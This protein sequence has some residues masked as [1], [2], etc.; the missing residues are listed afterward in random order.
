VTPEGAL[1]AAVPTGSRAL[2]I[3]RARLKG[4]RGQ[5]SA[6]LVAVWVATLGA[7]VLGAAVD[8]P[9]LAV[10]P[11]VVAVV[12]VAIAK[13]PLRYTLLALAFLALVLEN[14]AENPGAGKWKSPVYIVG[15]LLL[16]NLN[17]TLPVKALRFSGLDLVTAL[18]FAVWLRRRILGRHEVSPGHAGDRAPA[19]QG[20]PDLLR[21]GG[22]PDGLGHRHPRRLHQR[23]LADAEAALRPHHLRL[24]E[25]DVPRAGR[26]HADRRAG[27]RRGDLE[28]AGRHVRAVDPGA[29]PAVRHQ[30]RGLRAVRHRV[31]H[32]A[33]PPADRRGQEELPALPAGVATGAGWSGWR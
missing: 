7:M 19:A 28:G 12:L 9:I 8:Q 6:M 11:L 23:A 4:F 30:P 14:P 10:V 21:D 24:D 27:H 3:A 2:A 20:V 31:L 25:R 22:L 33:H 18:L 15:A 5:W 26:P 13:A 16:A 17:T 29:G 32:P 1:Y